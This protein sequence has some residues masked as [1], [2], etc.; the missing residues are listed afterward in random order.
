L[1]IFLRLLI[2]LALTAH[3]ISIRIETIEMFIYWLISFS[4]EVNSVILLSIIECL[5]C[6]VSLLYAF[7]FLRY[8]RLLVWALFIFIFLLHMIFFKSTL[9]KMLL[10]KIVPVFAH[11]KATEIFLC[12]IFRVRYELRLRNWLIIVL[13]LIFKVILFLLIL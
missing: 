8:I 13:N 4:W 3:L 6:Q 9:K 10:C 5:V 12:S 1:F 2:L 7:I 11:I